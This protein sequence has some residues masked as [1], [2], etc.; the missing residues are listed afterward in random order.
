MTPSSKT[1]EEHGVKRPQAEDDAA[2]K[3]DKAD[4]E[5]VGH[6]QAARHGLNADNRVRPHL[7]A[8]DGL[9]HGRP[10]HVAHELRARQ[11]K[12]RAQ[13]RAGQQNDQG[14]QHIAELPLND[15]RIVV[16]QEAENL[17]GNWSGG[18]NK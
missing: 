2:G 18:P 1:V 15:G 14:K 16:A 7:V 4:A 13:Q 17:R 8:L 9:D 3:G 10:E 6:D 12:H 5:V 11:R